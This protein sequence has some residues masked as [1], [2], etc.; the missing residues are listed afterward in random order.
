VQKYISHYRLQKLISGPDDAI[1]YALGTRS[2]SYKISLLEIS[3]TKEGEEPSVREITQVP[4][5]FHDDD[6]EAMFFQEGDERYILICILVG[7]NG[8]FIYRVD[9][10]EDENSN[11]PRERVRRSN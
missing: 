1:I 7:S 9:L 11:G 3:L 5:L 2:P 4:D 8:R 6:F 10:Q